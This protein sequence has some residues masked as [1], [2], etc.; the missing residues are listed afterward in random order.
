[1]S[2]LE[3]ERSRAEAERQR[4]EQAERELSG[5]D[6]ELADQEQEMYQNFYR[7]RCIAQGEGGRAVEI[8]QFLSGS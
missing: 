5:K 2:Q 1:M 3:D 4:R 8:C 6:K 7:S